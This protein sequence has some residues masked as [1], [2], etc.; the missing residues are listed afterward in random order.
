[1]SSAF[2]TPPSTSDIAIVTDE[3]PPALADLVAALEQRGL[4]TQVIAAQ[5]LADHGRAGVA[6]VRRLDPGL[7]NV[8]HV[9]HAISAAEGPAFINTPRSVRVCEWSPLRHHMLMRAGVPQPLRAWCI[10]A[11]DLARASETFG[12]PVIIE[13]VRSRGRLR[14]A[15]R[16]AVNTAA[17]AVEQGRARYGV[18]VEQPIDGLS[19]PIRV[20]IADGRAIGFSCSDGDDL[21]D[22]DATTI[23]AAAAHAV[24]AL[25]GR[26]MAASVASDGQGNSV[27]TSV[28]AAPHIAHFGASAMDAVADVIAAHVRRSHAARTLSHRRRRPSHR[29]PHDAAVA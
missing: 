14:A 13:S 9:A 18:L 1:M 26:I 7:T 24:A 29:G 2:L 25:G 10:D 27:V 3:S 11:N 8:A 20:L 17:M 16:S 6:Y 5:L 28:D 15:D 4:A 19:A 12:L 23:E 21:G 22:R